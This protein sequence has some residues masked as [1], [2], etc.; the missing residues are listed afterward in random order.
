MHPMLRRWLRLPFIT[1][2]VASFCAFAAAGHFAASA[3]L[4]AQGSRQLQELADTA[5]RRAEAAVDYGTITLDELIK[6]ARPVSCDAAALQGVRLHVYQRGAVKDIRIVNRDASVIC[7]AYS[8]TLEFDKAWV[9]RDE[10]LPA[11]DQAIRLFRVEQFF[12]VALGLLKDVDDA[13][14][15]VAILSVNASLL[16][17]LPAA[18]RPHGEVVLQLADG[19]TIAR[20]PSA[21][22]PAPLPHRLLFAHASTHYPLR[23]TIRVDAAAFEQ[24]THEFYLPMLALALVLG[25]LFGLLLGSAIVRPQDAVAELDAALAAREFQPYFQPLFELRSGAIVGCEALARWVR[26]DGSVVPPARFI[27]L[28]EESGRIEPMT[29]QLLSAAL[30]ELRPH[31]KRDKGFKLSIN[32][33]PHHLVAAGF[34]AELQ[35]I[36]IDAGV[37]ARQIVIELTER[38]ELADLAQA[39]AVVAELREKGFHVAIDDVGV[40]HSGLSQIQRLGADVMKVDKF[41]IDSITRDHTALAVVKI[42]V[43][44][45]RE[46]RMS[47]VAE[48]IESAEQMAALVACGIDEGQG[49]LVS[50]PLPAREFA[51]FLRRHAEARSAAPPPASSARV[52]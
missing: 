24:W 2:V 44:L 13:R 17:I 51:D 42:M 19:A 41:F 34:V 10:M 21:D 46:L 23:T 1:V 28:A 15:L 26:A 33:A 3:L 20:Y 7:S 11:R 49:Y 29:W 9:R 16:D 4:A 31:L 18:L 8:E 36:V 52:A 14:S 38:E 12:G 39:A 6:E 37:S 50:P 43:G 5:L 35:R 27:K 40:G 32:V 22:P 30:V 47:V 48:G 25:L 45:A